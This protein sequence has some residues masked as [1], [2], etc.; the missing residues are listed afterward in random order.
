M[1]AKIQLSGGYFNYQKVVSIGFKNIYYLAET[2]N[3]F[4]LAQQPSYI[5]FDTLHATCK[6]DKDKERR[7]LNQFIKMIPLSIQKLKLDIKE[8]DRSR[9]LK[10]IHFMAPQ[11]VFFGID[12]F[13]DLMKR[14]KEIE[15]LP[16]NVLKNQVLAG[17]N[18]IQS[19]LEE[20][21]TIIENQ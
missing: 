12:Y 16:F 9:L 18:K 4:F 3:L 21:K 17:I 8:E 6:G 1:C 11:L 20:V 15:H 19:A 7:Y 10:E 2:I 14:E 13:S 5:N